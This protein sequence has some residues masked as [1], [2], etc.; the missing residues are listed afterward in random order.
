MDVADKLRA[1]ERKRIFLTAAGG[2][3]TFFYLCL[4]GLLAKWSE[5]PGMPLNNIGDF[6]AGAFAPLAFWWLVIGYFLQALELKQNSESLMQQAA[7]MRNAVEQATEQAGALKANERY[8]KQS[9]INET[10]K[11]YE[12]DLA[13]TSAKILVVFINTSAETIESYWQRF[14]S[15]EVDVFARIIHSKIQ[16]DGAALSSMNVHKNMGRLMPV[17]KN[18]LKV[19][20]AFE[21]WLS[22]FD[23]SD[24][25]SEFYRESAFGAL[26][27]YMNSLWP[28]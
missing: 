6:L 26:R 9:I 25:L 1:L 21:C 22:D 15:G 8:S 18:Y 19:F 27:N 14:Q 20:S 2:L 7:E 28:N 12:R 11:I 5:L 10:R 16:Q 17:A 24:Y 3:G 13:L 4:L 23:D